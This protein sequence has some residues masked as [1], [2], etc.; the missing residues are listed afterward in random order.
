MHRLH[1]IVS[2][3]AD[4][5]ISI[6]NAAKL[7]GVSVD[8]LRRWDKSGKLKSIRN[9][10]SGHRYF[11]L[12]DIQLYQKGPMIIARQWAF[13]TGASPLD[14][15]FHCRT[16]DVFQARLET[17]QNKLV[18][19]M[20][21][22]RASL[23]TAIAGE[24][25]NN[26]FDHNLGNWPDELGIF[27]S[28]TQNREIVLAD[29]GRGILLTLRQVDAT[30]QTHSQALVAAFTRQISGRP[31]E[32]RGNGL[33]FVKRVVT[34]RPIGLSFQTGDALIELSEHATQID[35]KIAPESLRGCFVVIS[36]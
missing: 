35:V 23:I 33:K 30:L 13:G 12:D 26:S 29:R 21:V 14:P 16:R 3:T 6:G 1:N 8:T 36:Y 9:G 28:S 2:M 27:F 7:I 17:L 31:T 4:T 5:N 11:N 22:E 18:E 15:I 24:I 10:L 20:G 25:G 32:G 19:L 34:T